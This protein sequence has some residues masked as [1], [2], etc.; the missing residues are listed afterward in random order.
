[1]GLRWCG[2]SGAVF[3]EVKWLSLHS[4]IT[5]TISSTNLLTCFY[6]LP[7]ISTTKNNTHTHTQQV[8]MQL[9]NKYRMHNLTIH[10]FMQVW[11]GVCLPLCPVFWLVRSL[12][13]AASTQTRPSPTLHPSIRYRLH[14][15]THGASHHPSLTY[16]PPPPSPTKTNKQQY[17]QKVVLP[18]HREGHAAAAPAGPLLRHQCRGLVP[19]R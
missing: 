5:G 6:Y 18:P 9:I 4:L 11:L 19:T 17:H 8:T 16:P 13:P 12:L 14:T 2:G 15:P 10:T 1:M 3:I 7:I